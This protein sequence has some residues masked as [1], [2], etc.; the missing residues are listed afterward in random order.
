M[1]MGCSPA[2]GGVQTL[3]HVPQLLGSVCSLTQAVPQRVGVV[4]GQQVVPLQATPPGHEPQLTMPPQP[5][6]TVPQ[7]SPAGQLVIGVQPQTFAVP[8]PPHV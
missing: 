3:S 1:H 8:P 5:S 7:L 6:G 4:P 2:S